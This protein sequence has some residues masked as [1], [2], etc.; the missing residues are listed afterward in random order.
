M[1]GITVG[2][3]DNYP[4]NIEGQYIDVTGVAAGRYLLVHRITVGG[5]R[6]VNPYNDVSCAAIALKA[7]AAAGAPPTVTVLPG[8]RRCAAS[9]SRWGVRTR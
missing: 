4:A 2:W 1:E 9:Y 8:E 5:L 3:G 6:E 7:P